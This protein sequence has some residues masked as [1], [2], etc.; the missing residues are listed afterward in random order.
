M[1]ATGPV[2]DEESR[3]KAAQVLVDA[4]FQ[5]QA[6]ENDIGKA[7]EQGAGV[8]DGRGAGRARTGFYMTL[9]RRKPWYSP[10]TASS[11]PPP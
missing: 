3:L 9:V 5:L 11:R 2:G 10:G 4:D 1:Q 6:L 8:H 7:G